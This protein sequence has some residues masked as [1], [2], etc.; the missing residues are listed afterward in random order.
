ML[1]L[2]DEWLARHVLPA[3]PA[4]RGWLR[5]ARH[6]EFDI[7]DIIQETYARLV[8]APGLEK[9]VHVRAYL[10]RTAHS[11]VADRYRRKNIVSIADLAD[12]EKLAHAV[13][14]LTPEDHAEASNEL[15]VLIEITSTFP[16]KT[17]TIF[18]LSRVQGL[19]I[20]EIT[21]RTGIPASTV[22]KHV[23]RAFRLLMDAYADGGYSVPVTSSKM[24][25]RLGVV[26]GKGR[27][28]F[29]CD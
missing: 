24:A 12:L 28:T 4:L 16:E 17:R 26:G 3:E 11:V 7:D 6:A 21:E 20:K 10:F 8:Q 14:V 19:S 23:A 18:M 9:V 15:R 29:G 2:R 27:E 1:D 5:K 13:D 22:E 25:R